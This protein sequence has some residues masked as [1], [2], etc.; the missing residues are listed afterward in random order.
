MYHYKKKYLSF[1]VFLKNDQAGMLFFLCPNGSCV[2]WVDGSG[3]GFSLD[4]PSIS[5]HAISR[6]LSAYPAEHLYIQVNSRHQGRNTDGKT[7]LPASNLPD[8]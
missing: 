8:V 6:D 7:I 2:S 3:V 4:Y 1:Q 5:L